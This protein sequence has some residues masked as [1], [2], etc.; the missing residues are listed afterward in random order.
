MILRT[1]INQFK[2][3]RVLLRLGIGGTLCL[4]AGTMLGCGKP[5]NVKTRTDLP[6]ANYAASTA[7][8]TISIQAQAIRDEDFLYDT[9]DANLI[10]AGVLPVRVMLRN[11]SDRTVDLQKARFEI[12]QQGGRGFKAVDARGAFKRL[13]SYYEISAYNKSGYKES[14]GTFSEYGVDLKTPLAPGQSRQ[15]LMFFLV[16]GEAAHGAGLTLVVSRLGAESHPP[17]ELKLN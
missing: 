2:S 6:P 3:A 13:I 11:S 15:G 5:F 8:D 14:L 7:T 9:F 1:S 12:R 4:F 10:S 17:V 16:P